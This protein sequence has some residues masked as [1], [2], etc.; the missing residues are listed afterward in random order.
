MEATN[1]HA[2]LLDAIRQRTVNGPR[3]I[4]IDGV[5][6][7]GKSSLGRFLACE[8]AVPLIETDLFLDPEK[9]KGTYRLN[10]IQAV[11]TSRFS[12]DRPVILEGIFVLRLLSDLRIEPNYLI[13]VENAASRESPTMTWR[14]TFDTYQ[15]EFQSR[16]RADFVLTW[17]RR[18]GE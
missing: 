6:G 14:S 3:M 8:L 9:G 18:P 12:A 7:G 10:D 13:Y 1:L 5:D 16:K 4:A 17:A 2:A 11:I 15:D